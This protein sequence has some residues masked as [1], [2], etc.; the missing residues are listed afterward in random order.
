M[1]G[2]RRR[3]REL[4]T[5]A[6]ALGWHLIGEERGTVSFAVPG[7]GADTTLTVTLFQDSQGTPDRITLWSGPRQLDALLLA[8][9]DVR[10]PSRRWL[11]FLL[12]GVV[13]QHAGPPPGELRAALQA[14]LA[15]GL[16]PEALKDYAW[17]LGAGGVDGVVLRFV[18]AAVEIEGVL[19][20]ARRPPQVLAAD[21]QVATLLLSGSALAQLGALL[22][23]TTGGVAPAFRVWVG[24]PCSRVWLETPAASLDVLRQVVEFDR[25]LRARVPTRRAAGSR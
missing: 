19:P 15:R 23:R 9:T 14:A 8:I 18:R 22:E 24:V 10:D 6:R 3:T 4:L 21:E 7:C 13:L 20:H 17:Q 11:P 25:T 1:P 5:Q 2:I 16:P 12:E